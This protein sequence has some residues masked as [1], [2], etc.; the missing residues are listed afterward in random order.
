MKL[1]IT[2]PVYNVEKYFPSC[3]ESVLNQSYIK[4]NPNDFEI[5]LVDDGAKDQSGKMC[6]D[7]ATKYDF[8]KV[9]HQENKGLAAARNVCIEN[10]TG[11]YISMIDADD[12]IH[13]KYYEKMVSV[14][15]KTGLSV[16]K[17]QRYYLDDGEE[18]VFNQII[19]KKPKI[20]NTK[21][22]FEKDIVKMGH[23]P[24][25]VDGMC[26]KLYR[27][28]IIG[29]LRFNENLKNEE[30]FLFICE[31]MFKF[32]K[33][34]KI[35]D[36]LYFVVHNENSN[37]NN[38]AYLDRNIA[39][40]VD[41]KIVFINKLKELNY[42]K[43]NAIINNSLFSIFD[44]LEYWVYHR[45]CEIPEKDREKILNEFSVFEKDITSLFIKIQ[46]NALKKRNY[47]TI[48]FFQMK[49]MKSLYKS[50]I[51]KW[52]LKFVKKKRKISA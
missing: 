47:K 51:R 4:N 37:T 9:I 18:P 8:I 11:E 1:S 22:A 6:D 48:G 12:I 25:L 23:K 26:T 34:A 24:L 33:F 7:Y 44:E 21:E 5:I 52:N 2:I 19:N 35:D 49:Y 31:L 36:I 15:E 41:S 13:P 29:D 45:K 14:L 32:E 39:S 43:I 42:H 16:V 30:D 50:I 38:S 3:M 40:L 10:A 46:Y 27:R 20:H 28:D 17:C